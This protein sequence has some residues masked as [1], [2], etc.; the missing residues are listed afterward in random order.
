[1]CGVAAGDQDWRAAHRKFTSDCDTNSGAA[2]GYNRDLTL[3]AEYVFQ[4]RKPPAFF[5]DLFAACGS[6]ALCA[7]RRLLTPRLRSGLRL[8]RLS[9]RHSHAVLLRDATGIATASHYACVARLI[10]I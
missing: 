7:R 10:V 1:M 3:D 4:S 2:A 9:R 5:T 8:I 6:F